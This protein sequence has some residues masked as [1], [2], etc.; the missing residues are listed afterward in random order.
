MVSM[1]IGE[2]EIVEQV[3]AVLPIIAMSNVYWQLFCISVREAEI[4]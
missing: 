4:A 2:D 1:G 3:K